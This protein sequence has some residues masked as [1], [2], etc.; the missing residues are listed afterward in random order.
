VGDTK[1]LPKGLIWSQEQGVFSNFVLQ[2]R[3][4]E[5]LKEADFR[6]DMAVAGASP[7][8]HHHASPEHRRSHKSHAPTA[9]EKQ[10]RAY[11]FSDNAN[12]RLGNQA[13]DA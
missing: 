12:K 11:L 3:V 7:H 9:E 8:A 13:V 1:P 5:N 4:Q 6:A 10:A 2:E